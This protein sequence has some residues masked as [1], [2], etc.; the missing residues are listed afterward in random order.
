MKN[1]LWHFK[2][3]LKFQF[4]HLWV[5]FLFSFIQ[6]CSTTR[7]DNVQLEG[8]ID[9][10]NIEYYWKSGLSLGSYIRS[11][12]QDDIA[13]NIAALYLLGLNGGNHQSNTFNYN[14]QNAAPVFAMN[15]QSHGP[16]NEEIENP[17]LTLPSLNKGALS[18]NIKNNIR[19]LTGIEYISKGGKDPGTT[20]HLN[21]LEVPFYV[22]YW[23][24]PI[25]KGNIFGGLGPYI[26][27][28]IGGNTKTSTDKWKSF[29]NKGDFK[30][31]DAGLTFTA[32]YKMTNSF[33]FR[34][35]YD[36]G[37]VNTAK[38]APHSKTHNNN[39]SLNIGYPLNRIYKNKK[40]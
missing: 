37:M 3:S 25:A 12:S 22:T 4:T 27:Y 16:F 36:K 14:I 2:K 10:T 15:S 1:H 17:T 31:F 20:T 28:G 34:I 19:F 9:K 35:A 6:S 30:P 38:D 24:N 21:Y 13:L 33:S 26:A 7:F 32:G 11:P 5:I 8:S 29:G 23:T 18:S 39:L 40:H